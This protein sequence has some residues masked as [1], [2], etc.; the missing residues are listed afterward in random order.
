MVG[1]DKETRHYYAS[2]VPYRRLS[3]I[4]IVV[5]NYVARFGGNLIYKFN[6]PPIPIIFFSSKL[7]AIK[8]LET[9][10]LYLLN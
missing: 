4:A 3:A 8:W 2:D 9:Y 5:D 6:K 7:K 1:I 10:K